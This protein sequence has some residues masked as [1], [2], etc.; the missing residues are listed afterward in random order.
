MLRRFKSLTRVSLASVKS[1]CSRVFIGYDT[2]SDLVF[3]PP[4]TLDCINRYI[5]EDRS[6]LSQQPYWPDLKTIEA[7]SVRRQETLRDSVAVSFLSGFD[8]WNLQAD[9][10]Q[11]GIPETRI[12]ELEHVASMPQT[13]EENY[14]GYPIQWCCERDMSEEEEER[15]RSN[16]RYNLRRV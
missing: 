10:F 1:S 8:L 14:R 12:V 11:N 16:A 15:P 6:F 9:E 2:I 13:V 4:M 7:W 3:Q 5:F